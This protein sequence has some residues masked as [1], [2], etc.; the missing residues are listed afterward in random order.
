MNEPSDAVVIAFEAWLEE[1]YG[2]FGHRRENIMPHE[3]PMV[4]EAWLR[5][6]AW[7]LRS[8][9]ERLRA[10]VEARMPLMAVY[11]DQRAV[12]DTLRWVLTEM[13]DA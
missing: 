6:W 4:R 9:R 2:D 8:E 12:A 5:A 3:M 1:P 11:G 10:A 7:T 13:V